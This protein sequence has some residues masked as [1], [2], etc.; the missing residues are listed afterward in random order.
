MHIGGKVIA[1]PAAH[2]DDTNQAVI[3]EIRNH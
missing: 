3:V 2:I 1:K